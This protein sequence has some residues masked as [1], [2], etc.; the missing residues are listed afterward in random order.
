MTT[1]LYCNQRRTAPDISGRLELQLSPYNN[2][3]I[4]QEK[5]NMRRKAEILKYNATTTNSQ[6]NSPNKKQV[7]SQI[8]N[9][10]YKPCEVDTRSKLISTT[11]SDIPGKPMY[12]FEDSTMPLY[13]Y[14]NRVTFGISPTNA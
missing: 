11:A 4:T 10:T 9:G 1:P 14:R 5:L 6:T 7:F 3:S 13:N 8:I 2:G 12:L